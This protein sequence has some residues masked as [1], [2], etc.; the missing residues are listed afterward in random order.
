M[1]KN[2]LECHYADSVATRKYKIFLTSDKYEL[3]EFKILFV[4]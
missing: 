3:F 4:L 2:L 1:I